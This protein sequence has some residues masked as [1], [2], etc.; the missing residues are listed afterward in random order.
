LLEEVID[1]LL[2]SEFT[3]KLVHVDFL[4]LLLVLHESNNLIIENQEATY[5]VNYGYSVLP[6]VYRLTVF[7]EKGFYKMYFRIRKYK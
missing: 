1:L 3:L 4:N 2:T 5:M 7:M 6:H